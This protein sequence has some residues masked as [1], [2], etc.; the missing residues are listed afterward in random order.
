MRFGESDIYEKI[1]VVTPE[2]TRA[3]PGAL[4]TS[5]L[6]PNEFVVGLYSIDVTETSLAL[7]VA[8][9]QL[10]YAAMVSDSASDNAV[11]HCATSSVESS[12]SP[13]SW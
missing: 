5:K 8:F 9:H 10:S 12:V 13:G 4:R 6:I 2:L 7:T 11:V 1:Q 3:P